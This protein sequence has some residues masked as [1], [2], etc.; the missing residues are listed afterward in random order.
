[1][2]SSPVRIHVS[3]SPPA[4]PVCREISAATMK[5]PDPIIEPTTI[6]VPSNNPMARTKPVGFLALLCGMACVV[7][8]IQ[9]YLKRQPHGSRLPEVRYIAELGAWDQA[10]GGYRSQPQRNRR[11]PE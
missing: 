7:S 5:I 8:A 6:M 1:M 11:R 9:G 10:R 2:V 4:E 3:S